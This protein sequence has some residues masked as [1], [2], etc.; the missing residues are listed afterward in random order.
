MK[1]VKLQERVLFISLIFLQKALPVKA[2]ITGKQTETAIGMPKT[3]QSQVYF[4]S[5]TPFWD[6]IERPILMVAQ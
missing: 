6:P 4:Q 1:T 3:F 2:Q 5:S